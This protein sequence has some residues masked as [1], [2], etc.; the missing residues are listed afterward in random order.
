MAI[1]KGKVLVAA[2]VHEVLLNGL[3]AEGY[4]CDI[5]EKINQQLAF[6]LIKDCV[7]VVTSTRLQLNKELIDAAP[8]LQWIGR[9]GSGMEVIDVPY[10]L[11]KGIKCCSSPEGNRNAVAEH[12]L[13]MLLSL[14]KRICASAEEVKEGKW[15]RDENRGMEMEGKTIGIIG[16]GNTGSAF[17]KKLSGFDV[18]IIAYD[19]CEENKASDPVV[20]CNGLT[21]IFEQADIVSFHVPLQEDTH[22]YFNDD[23]ITQMHKPFILINTSR[24]KIVD[25]EAMLRGLESKKI[26]GAVLDVWEEEPLDKMSDHMK[27]LLNKA[28]QRPN[29]IVTPHI[30]GY[31]FEALYKMSSVLLDK[32]VINK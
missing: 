24:G 5:H 7:G 27:Q 20:N 19:T 30:A 15:L 8:N 26:L 28:I 10:A 16:Y 9:M 17:A 2:P 6:S 23:F 31:S 21:P 32:I 11:S 4:T 25:T 22:H 13:G 3:E 14:T 29:V 18:K 12:A 1:N